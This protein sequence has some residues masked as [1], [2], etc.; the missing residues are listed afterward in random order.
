M[1]RVLAV[2]GGV[3]ALGVHAVVIHHL[4]SRFAWPVLATVALVTLVVVKHTGV[5]G[6]LH[7]RLRPRS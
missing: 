5:L 7:D 6:A 1:K 4:S 2:L 3:V